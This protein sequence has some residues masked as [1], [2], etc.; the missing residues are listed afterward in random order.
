[1]TL[2]SVE[3]RFG[4]VS[5]LP[6]PIQWLS[7]N[8]PCYV[9]R[10]TVAF[11]R[12]LGFDV[13]TTPAYSPESNSMAEA[14]VKTIKHDYEAYADLQNA[15]QVMEQRLAIIMKLPLAMD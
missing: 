1:M 15:Q 14:L 10:D 3:P 11:A 8:G 12:T 4:K 9:A 7:D 13:C 6:H 5:I 2:D